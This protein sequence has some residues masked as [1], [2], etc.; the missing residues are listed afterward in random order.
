M[1]HE[2][3]RDGSYG[4]RN[5]SVNLIGKWALFDRYLEQMGKNGGS[6]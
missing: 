5:S 1:M 4:A 6:G 2:P 3:A